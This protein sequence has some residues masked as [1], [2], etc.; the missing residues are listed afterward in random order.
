MWFS[1]SLFVSNPANPEIENLAKCHPPL[2]I[3]DAAS[4][5]KRFSHPLPHAKIAKMTEMPPQPF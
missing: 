1:D 5:P 4:T 3:R 2:T